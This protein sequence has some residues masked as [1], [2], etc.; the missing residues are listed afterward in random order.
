MA[1]PQFFISKEHQNEIKIE[2]F[3]YRV[4]RKVLSVPRRFWAGLKKITTG[5]KKSQEVITNI[6][7]D[8]HPYM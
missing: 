2:L 4:L 6:F 5:R 7:D 3:V 8:E 1:S